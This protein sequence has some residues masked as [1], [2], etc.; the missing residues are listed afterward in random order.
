[1]MD[2]VETCKMENSLAIAP[3]MSSLSL[4][5]LT[6]S[7]QRRSWS[8]ERNGGGSGE[9]AEKLNGSAE[10]EEAARGFPAVAIADLRRLLARLEMAFP[11]V[12]DSVS[13]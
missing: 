13:F 6:A 5:A 4:K 1:M 8:G 3:G 10:V 7:M 9:S 2:L 11:V 12:P